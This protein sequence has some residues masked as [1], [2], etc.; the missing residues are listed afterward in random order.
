MPKP[1]GVRYPKHMSFNTST[2]QREEIDAIAGV[3]GLYVGEVT[4]GLLDR[5]L[6]AYDRGVPIGTT[7]AA[8]EDHV[9]FVASVEQFD[10]VKEIAGERETSETLRGLVHL[11]LVAYHSKGARW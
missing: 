6:A 2:E 9:S 10:R 5:G 3:H 8:L 1:P 11:G 7:S 4:R